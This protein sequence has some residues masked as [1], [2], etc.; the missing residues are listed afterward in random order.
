MTASKAKP[1]R[2][3]ASDSVPRRIRKDYPNPKSE[4]EK[5]YQRLGITAQQMEGVAL[6]QPL[7]RRA[8][9]SAEQAV[10]ILSSDDSPDAQ[11]FMAVYRKMSPNDR[12]RASIEAIAVAAKLTT[13]RLWEVLSG[14]S[15]IQG[16]DVVRLMLSAAQ[17]EIV[18]RSIEGAKTE[19]GF[20]D[21]DHLYRAVGFFPTSKGA[22]VFI[23][24][25]KAA[26][27]DTEK[28][29]D[30]SD[31]TGSLPRMDDFILDI[32]KAINPSRTLPVPVPKAAGSEEFLD[33]P[34]GTL[35]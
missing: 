14:A 33:L 10:E 25:N 3:C 15:M 17:P 28:P 5:T 19:K 7:L 2:K 22:Q 8:G 30:D 32:Q 6:I 21:R 4:L 27:V 29:E 31:G 20:T 9:M 35:E 26:E 24:V 16:R 23:N 12:R 11:S 1:R 34:P 18:A 13:R